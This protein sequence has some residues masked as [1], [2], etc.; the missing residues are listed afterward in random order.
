MKRKILL[1]HRLPHQPFSVL[2]RDYDLSWPGGDSFSEEDLIELLPSC[3]VVVS[4]YSKPF[5]AE[6]IKAAP[7]L[8]LIANFGAGTN[9]IDVETATQKGIVVTNTPDSV[10]EPTA[11]VAM[12]LIVSIARR[13]PELDRALRQGLVKSWGVLD[14]MSNTLEGKT[15]G[16]IG[17]GAIGRSLARRACAFGM[18]IVYHNR[19]RLD[20][21]MEEKY[22]ARY[23]DMESVLRHSD[24]VSLNVPLTADTARLIGASELKLMKSTAFLI[25]TARGAVVDQKALIE[26]L[27]KKEIAGAALDV[28]ENEPEVPAELLKMNNVVLSPHMGGATHEAREMMSKQVAGIIRDFFE[29]RR[30]LP[31]VNP[32]V[33]D[34]SALRFKKVE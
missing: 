26:A 5:G 19:N 25:N 32:E 28:F 7:N 12:G 22:E 29:G 10:T 13:I 16:I 17:M 18:R 3:D 21:A 31:V 11:E 33:W 30:E 1:S 2:E 4:V 34:S 14:N 9:N 15:L 24:Y 27:T 20:T 6:A 8:K 23:T